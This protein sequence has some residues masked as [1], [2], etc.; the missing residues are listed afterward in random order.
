MFIAGIRITWLQLDVFRPRDILRAFGSLQRFEHDGH[1]QK[2]QDPECKDNN[3]R[4][5]RHL[6][7]RFEVFMF[8]FQNALQ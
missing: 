4:N 1:L 6:T 7:Q 5:F 3:T 8:L 2:R